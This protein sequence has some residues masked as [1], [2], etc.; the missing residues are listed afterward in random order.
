RRAP[1]LRERGRLHRFEVRRARLH[2]RAPRGSA[3]PPDPPDYRRS[4]TGRV[5]LLPRSLPR[6]RG[7]GEGAVRR[8]RPTP[9]RRRGR[10]RSLRGHASPPRQHRRA[11][12]QGPSPI[13]PGADR[14]ELS[15]PSSN[16][17]RLLARDHAAPE[18]TLALA[19]AASLGRERVRP[20]AWCSRPRNS[21]ALLEGA[22]APSSNTCRLLARDHAAP[23]PTL[24]LA[25]A[26]SLGR[27]RVRP[28][29]WCSRPRNSAAL[30]EGA[31]APSSNTCRLL[32]R[33]HAAP[34]P[35]LA[36]AKAASLGRERVRPL[37]WCSRPRNSAAL[38]EGASAPSSNTC[39]L[40]ARDH[41]APE[42][43]LALAKAAS[44]GRERVRPLAWCSRPRNSAALLE[45]APVGWL[46]TALILL[47][48]GGALLVWVFPWDGFTAGSIALLVALGE[49]GLW[50][51]ALVRFHFDRGGLQL[52]QRTNWF[53][54][55]HV[56]YHVGMYGFSLWLVGLTV[57]VQAAASAY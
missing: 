42:P 49:V 17:C 40:L 11:R 33:D 34:E 10:M 44:L 19:K 8:R 51:E 12:R 52:D 54:D 35:T 6:R 56:S 9:S 4:R 48:L 20:L 3:R 22:S 31:S 41:A 13:E 18:S 55:L 36:L 50:I 27:E 26:A 24:A 21:A 30:L 32:A 37:A 28:L 25:K 46:T 29:A 2:L 45:G 38:L 57:I 23:E 15:A 53:S 7:E 16:T 5:E 1:G 39:R 47:P 14:Q 43:T